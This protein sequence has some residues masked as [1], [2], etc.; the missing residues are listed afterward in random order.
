MH[1]SRVQCGSIWSSVGNPNPLLSITK[2]LDQSVMQA[3]LYLD[4]N[5]ENSTFRINQNSFSSSNSNSSSVRMD[6]INSS[7]PRR[8]L[9][10]EGWLSK[11]AEHLKTWRPRYFVLYENGDFLGF[12]TQQE[13]VSDK[14]NEPLNNF[15]VLNCQVLKTERPKPHTFILRGRV[16]E[17]TIL[18]IATLILSE[19]D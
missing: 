13:S 5:N 19:K 4:S 10:K 7:N 11:R 6:N 3:H 15:T 17:N 18:R 16:R 1:S 8:R 2:R 9:V 12:R 14:S